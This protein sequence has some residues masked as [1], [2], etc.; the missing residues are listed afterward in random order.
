MT[1]ITEFSDVIFVQH[2]GRRE[3]TVIRNIS[4]LFILCFKTAFRYFYSKPATLNVIVVDQSELNRYSINK[5]SITI[6]ETLYKGNW[7]QKSLFFNYGNNS[8]S[9][10]KF[11]SN[12]IHL[13]LR[14]EDEKCEL[15]LKMSHLLKL[16]Q[17]FP[18]LTILSNSKSF[19]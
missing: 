14:I 17:E 19:K 1:S 4:F 9:K 10:F 12:S 13:D 3:V 7:K 18:I 15:K 2:I 6:S 11:I 5:L 16:N 8:K